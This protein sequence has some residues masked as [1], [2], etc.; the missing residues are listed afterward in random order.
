[1]II[2]TNKYKPK[3]SMS[4]LQNGKASEI[5]RA[6]GLSER[7]LQQ[8]I[9]NHCDDARSSEKQKIYRE[10]YANREKS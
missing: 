8:E 9:R 6:H 2:L 4:E 1:M 7:G 10:V 5:M 3:V